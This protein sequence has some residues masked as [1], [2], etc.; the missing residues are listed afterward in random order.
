LALDQQGK[1]SESIAAIKKA[2]DLLREQGRTQDADK[3]DEG[4]KAMGQK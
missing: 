2:R 4:L 1:K 3:I